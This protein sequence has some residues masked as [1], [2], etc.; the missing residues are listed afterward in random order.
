MRIKVVKRGGKMMDLIEI[1]D[2]KEE[3]V[4]RFKRDILN[5]YKEKGDE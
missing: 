3:T 5:N 2:E 1:L 4:I